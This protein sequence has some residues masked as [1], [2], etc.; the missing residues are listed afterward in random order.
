MRQS[1]DAIAWQHFLQQQPQASSS[2]L[3]LLAMGV[4]LCSQAQAQSPRV[5]L[6][7]V[8]VR[9]PDWLQ[10][11]LPA[12]YS[13]NGAKAT[14][15]LTGP[16]TILHWNSFDVGANA[17]LRFN[18]P[19][20]T[21]RVLNKVDGGAWQKMSTIEGALRS[22]GQVY[23][24][25]PNGILFGKG[26]TVN[27]NSLVASSLK[28]DDQRFM[29]GLLSPGVAPNLAQDPALP[30]GAVAGPVVVEG[31]AQGGTLQR[32]ALTAQ[33]NGLILLAAPQVSNSGLLSAPDGQVLLAAGSRVFL[34][35]P[36]SSAMRGLRVEVASDGLSALAGGAVV[37]NT[38][39]GQVDVA[40][41]NATLV[42]MAV[43]QLGRV[44]ATTSVSLNGSIYLK[45]Q[46]G[47][48]KASAE[49]APV[50]SLGG[51]L[52]LGTGSR[53]TVLPTLDDTTT[54][55][56]SGPAFK[57]SV[58]QLSGQTIVLQPAAAVVAPGGSIELTA[59]LNPGADDLI[60]N[61]SRIE[62]GAGSVLD[63][64]GSTGTQLSV[65]ANVVSAELRGGELADNVLLRDSAL[66]GQTV[67]FDRRKAPA[68]LAVA[69]VSG[70]LNLVEQGVGEL[71][72]AGGNVS[73]VSEGAIDL[74]TGS[75]VAVSGGWVDYQAGHVNTS[76][77]T[78]G[79]RLYDIETAPAGL[80]YDG[81]VNLANS[82]AT[83]EAG[84]RAGRSAGTLRLNAAGLS[85]DGTLEGQVTRGSQQRDLA[86]SGQA[87][88]GQLLLG[89]VSEA[90]MDTAT[91]RA[92]FA[93]REQFRLGSKLV[94][95]SQ[96]GGA[97]ALKLDVAALGAA[98]FS[99]VTALTTGDIVVAEP[100][101]LPAGGQLR[102]GSANDVAL[103][104]S[105][106]VPGGDVTVAAYNRLDVAAGVRL[107]VSGAWQN[108]GALAEPPRDA[109]NQPSGTYLTRGG[110]LRLYGNQ[111][112]L[113][114]DVAVNASGGAWLNASGK[115]TAG[116]AGSITV[117]ATTQGNPLDASLWL[118]ER[119]SFEGYGLGKGG[120][121]SLT[122]RHVTVGGA[123]SSPAASADLPDLQLAAEFFKSGGF[124]DYTLSANGNLTVAAGAQL[125]VQA[126]SW[127]LN[128]DF[129]RLRSGAMSQAARIELLPLA[130][131]AG[132]RLASNLTLR[133]TGRSLPGDGLGILRLAEGSAIWS[134]PG[135]NV[136]LSA[137]RQIQLAGTVRAP[138]GT[139]SALLLAASPGTDDLS[140]GLDRGIWLGA[141]ARL[142][143]PG[144]TERLLLDA[145]GVSSGEVLA[146]G[147]VRLGRLGSSG[148]EA[149]VGF[150]VAEA[151]SVID[152]SGAQALGLR[153]KG[154][155]YLSKPLTVGSDGGLI[156]VRA[157]EGL[158]LAG[159]LRGAA[160]SDQARGGSLAVVLDR[161][162]LS[163]SASYPQA[164]RELVLSAGAAQ[165]LTPAGLHMGHAV[166]ELEGQGRVSLAAVNAGGFANLRFKS[167]QRI[168][169]AGDQ[170][171]GGG[172][173]AIAAS[174]SVTLDAPN[175]GAGLA[176]GAQATRALV[177]APYVNLGSLDERYQAPGS[178]TDG[179]A[180]LDVVA[181]TL[182]LSG[183]SATQGFV[184]VK[185]AAKG[186]IRLVG[187]AQADVF[188]AEGGLQTGRQLT[189]EAAQIYPSTLSHFEIGLLGEQSEL[190]FLGNGRPAEAVLSAGG[191]VKARA[192]SI[193][194]AGRLLAPMGAIEL[195]AGQ[196]IR[197][198]KNSITSVAG[199]GYVPFGT[200]ANGTD[201]QY[202]L[203]P[204]SL[205]I[206]GQPKADPAL[207]EV[208][209]PAKRIVST[210]PSV[211]QAE[212][213]R[214][215]L[216]GGGTLQAYEFSPGPGGSADVLQSGSGSQQTFAIN[217]SFKAA[218]APLDWQYGTDGLAVGDQVYLT[219]ADGLPAGFYTLLPG[220]YAL[221]PG[222]YALDP[223]SRSRDMSPLDN[224]V[225]ADGSMT[226]AGYRR[227]STDGRGDT[228]VSGYVVSP[229]SLVRLRSEFKLFDANAFFKA[230]PG[231]AGLAS[232]NLPE[233]GGHLVFDVSRQLRLDGS[234]QLAGARSASG[235]GRAGMVDIS[236]PR[237]DLVAQAALSDRD[238][239]IV[240]V[241]VGSLVALGADS[242]LVG[243]RRSRV[244]GGWQ[245][246]VTA[247]T[248]RLDNDAANPLTGADIT[249]AAR[250]TVSL[251][252]RA[253]LAAMDTPQRAAEPWVLEG[254]GAAADGALL[255][256][257]GGAGPALTRSAPAL[258]HGRLEIE[259]GAQVRSQGSLYLDAT[260]SMAMK[261]GLYWGD[262]ASLT[263]RAPQINLGA[264]VPAA[265]TGLTLGADA[266]SDL[267]R[268]SAL[269]LRSYAGIDVWGEAVLGGSALSQLTLGAGVIRSHGADLRLAARQIT[270]L[271]VAS[272]AAS[273]TP[274]AGGGSGTFIASA[275][276][277]NL[278]NGQLQ[279]Q[280]FARTV[281]K[282]QNELIA[283]G[284]DSRLLVDNDLQL[285]AA[286][287]G[288]QA[289]GSGYVQAGGAM[290]LTANQPDRALA[291]AP[292]GGQLAF[293]AN[294]L[295]ANTQLVLPGGDLQLNA[296]QGVSV[297]GGLL[298]V[299]GEGV[300]FGTGMAYMPAGRITLSA[301][302][303]QVRVASAA[304]LDL[305]AQ[306]AAAGELRILGRQ[307]ALAGE[308]DGRASVGQ[309]ASTVPAQGRFALDM[310]QGMAVGAFDALNEQLNAAGF[311]EAREFR[312]RDGD[313]SLGAKGKM[314]AQRV[315]VAVDNGDLTI[316][317]TIDAS[318]PSGGSIELYA[319]QSQ[320][321]GNKGRLTLTD[322][323]R[324]QAQAK[325]A[326]TTSAGSLGDGG[327]VVLAA[328]NADGSAVSS[329]SGGA[330]ILGSA[331]SEI[332][333]SGLG[334]EAQAG[335][336]VLRAAR[337]GEGAGSDV[338]I[339]GFATLVK[340]GTATIEGVKTYSASRISE[341]SDAPGQLNAGTGG[342]M[343][344]DAAKF[345]RSSGT[346]QARLGR[347]DLA[348]TPGI[349][350][351]SSTDLTVC[352]NESALDRGARGWDLNPWRF[353]GQ[354]GTLSLRAAGNLVI[355]GAISDGFVKGQ[356]R[357][358]MPNWALDADAQSWSMRL[359]GGAALS[360]ANP[361]AV[362]PTVGSGDVRF[363]FTRAPL[364]STDPP[365]ALVRTGTGRIDVA[366]GR[367]VTLEKVTYLDPD[368]EALFNRDFG[369][370]L[371]TSGRASAL[372][373]TFVA[374]KNPVNNVYDT[375]DFGEGAPTVA[376]FGRDG[377]GISIQAQRDVNGAALPQLVNNWLF[378]QGRSGL[379]ADGV[380]AF[381]K[382]GDA[383]LNTAW[384]ARP[385]YLASGVATLGGGDVRV[386][387]LTGSVTDLSVS[388]ATNA[389]AT[390]VTLAAATLHEQGG[391]NLSVT[392]GVDIRGGKFY[393]QKGQ[394]TLRAK[395]SIGAGGFKAL[396][397]M[398]PKK[399]DA[400]GF[401]IDV[402]TALRPV[403][404]VG[405]ARFDVSA[406]QH[407]AV[408]S[409][410]NPML[411]AQSLNNVAAGVDPE[412]VRLDFANVSQ[413]ALDYKQRYAQYSAFSTYSADSGV[414]LT[415]VSGDLLLSNN[416]L[417]VANSAGSGLGNGSPALYAFAP[418]SLRAA[419]LAGSLS[420]EQGLVLAPAA[421]GQL[422]LMA[423][424]SVGLG[425]GGVF[426][427]G[428]TMLDNDPSAM[429]RPAAPTLLR[430]NDVR[431]LT[432]NLNGLAAHTPGQLHALD[433]SPARIVALKGDVTGQSGNRLVLTLPK[434]AEILAG[435][436]VRDLGFAIQHSGRSDETR[437]VAGRDV[438]D[439]TNIS[440]SSPVAHSVSGGGL[441]TI[442][443]GRDIDL[444]NAYGVITRGNLDNPYL[445]EGGAS[446]MAIAGATATPQQGF[447][448]NESF[449]KQLIKKGG[450]S[451]LP[452]FDALID[453]NFPFSVL[454][455][456]DIKVFGS[457]F[458]TEQGGS[459]DLFAPAGSV[460]AGLVSVPSY[461]RNKVKNNAADIGIFTVRGGAIRSLVRDNFVVNQGRVFTLGGGDITL[462]S[463][464][465][466]IDAGR[467]AK[468]ASSAPPPL[469]TT[470][471]SGNTKLDLA[472]S[473]SG[474]GIAT[475]Q[476]SDSQTPGNVYAVAPRGIFD[477]GDAGV[478][479]KGGV[480]IQA[481]VVLNAG[482]IQASSGVSGSV[483]FDAG[484][485]P[486][487][488]TAATSA[489]G[490][491]QDPT[492]QAL[493]APKELMALS[494]EVLG[495]GDADDLEDDANDSPEE[496]Q[497]KKR[498]RAA[499]TQTKL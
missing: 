299:H 238:D 382:V 182:D 497:R 360:A 73:L 427:N 59:R 354:A 321:G 364:D 95:G 9:A 270:L 21:S 306:G 356:S 454:T 258:S 27:V 264:S 225:N 336:V 318:G 181:N 390:G 253:S 119:V 437:L 242:L 196:Q 26:A 129:A 451:T 29:D 335:S 375:Q 396:D 74:Q 399:T 115:L 472:G 11:G 70:Y 3:A 236:A 184:Q 290:A 262:G 117:Q 175:L 141:G 144:S 224:R 202:E 297:T 176:A 89:N 5:P 153:F 431:Q 487:A 147:T 430:A 311:T 32:A 126:K 243:G 432:G 448:Q 204:Q 132:Q 130:S 128:N 361:L 372:P 387:A 137:V 19:S 496:K 56:V 67:R 493:V 489:A 342:A 164:P 94:L 91:G 300:A 357:D 20:T 304:K 331:G 188:V 123:L 241:G 190:V 125:S 252:H 102:L 444:G 145:A 345:M 150:V 124:A 401:D 227:N 254:T 233:D 200:V 269:D 429:S 478:R 167:E 248:I 428:L 310:A 314:V 283:G 414:Q 397:V 469:L 172:A 157:R 289:G 341:Q 407:L 462:V 66:R 419:A 325:Q 113:G 406:G 24:Y 12:S 209:L 133:A 391:G 346:I 92:N 220:H 44:T 100:L 473:V 53:S 440:D 105:V 131:A 8:P 362:V 445:P 352:V 197:Y 170:A 495:F 255:R 118:G 193:T 213:A 404:A 88:G 208:G 6:S 343:A 492:R 320:A 326:A 301:S 108:D 77:L 499:K 228:R 394:A 426:F 90:T 159:E 477:A 388:V 152:V 273:P 379:G 467:G 151:G 415:A 436:D 171:G 378:R 63:A 418:P 31:D 455:G 28:L 358:A 7:A 62:L 464:H 17:S 218:V 14:V 422:A 385:D 122:G 376:G 293:T 99:R 205:V 308:L 381:E 285:T 187:S 353:G 192:G 438:V 221:L 68:G 474:S 226:V 156:D 268:L 413:S 284:A 240:A 363:G 403:L 212:G 139:I 110:T 424:Q 38:P 446:V 484:A 247:D 41:G 109:Q 272:Q 4:L 465:G 435:R 142:L 459:I 286:R 246:A 389:Y 344:V 423:G 498:A 491:G 323:A 42:G 173:V 279:V 458:K 230:Q 460:Q 149:A 223:A 276:E 199:G 80:A 384:W 317:G 96:A 303:G 265:Q 261:G 16:A 442:Q 433:D 69:N 466:N 339:A 52:V 138:A 217:P 380:P 135:A 319:A 340:G 1:P 61:A 470:D 481:A 165:A 235:A 107:D 371:Y 85:L 37:T 482:N 34:A 417:L 86:A 359:V 327:R 46:G 76:K 295:S 355:Q 439:T 168:S 386:S 302:A 201:W 278:G 416:V 121:L 33:Q 256:A 257:S 292:A 367:D 369:A 103:N 231:Q 84:Y 408:E 87:L 479:S 162:G 120:G 471:S 83:Y 198:E 71:T 140:Y 366:A 412:A 45:A 13:V 421:A 15:N 328:A 40:R 232:P 211:V 51:T 449:F 483:G 143:A 43:N 54:V 316:A 307:V 447:A 39:V 488:P 402:F 494:V 411:T 98:G 452:E 177:T 93:V 333:V 189:L 48:T 183:R 309:G 298:D 47:A 79:G 185:L 195:T 214:L 468:T 186:D 154:G 155:A 348:V 127:V 207:G 296:A 332:D 266:L 456:G 443:A 158:L 2:V 263:A 291:A 485:A 75:R 338:A 476:T 25:N 111:L 365:V 288:V 55:A 349:E 351:R 237:I 475:L 377:G 72:A 337:V 313:V 222:G 275:K 373:T 239:G 206:R 245:V 10:R 134:D 463:Q 35:A 260:Q 82:N 64:S 178:A 329:V 161:E 395:G 274:Q 393:V 148:L 136:T 36:A 97:G 461:L 315:Q 166:P 179:Q 370:A 450:K 112:R 106:E 216:S 425:G 405:D 281:L 486:V 81:V 215:D 277:L 116:S 251:S 480:F 146:G 169:L 350:V 330:S 420:S 267:T 322:T 280:G 22:N 400:D 282:S 324:L 410:Y 57:P 58:V 18:L 271:G 191:V 49:A 287:V 434:L 374:P 334:A 398:A 30:A 174:S 453:L 294:T 490:A 368:G 249:L 409:I 244:D 347:T 101:R 392:A 160:G 50:A 259:A 383:W 23:I 65:A 78:L 180:V 312:V 250:D 104:A 219:G 194:Q 457:Q 60:P 114:V 441:L 234:S 305:H 163:G 229:Q 210:A 203:G